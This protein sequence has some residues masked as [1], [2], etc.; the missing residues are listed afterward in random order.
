MRHPRASARGREG[1]AGALH[2][3]Q[4][5]PSAEPGRDLRQ[6]LVG[7]HEAGVARAHHAAAPAQGRQRARGGRVRAHQLG[8]RLRT[9]HRAPRED[10]RH[11]PEEV[12]AVHRA[13]PDAGA[14]GPV[15]AAV[16]HAQLCGAR[17]LLLGQHGRG[18]DLHHRRQLL[19][20]RRAG[21]G[22][23]QAVRDD[24]HGRRPSQQPD[25]DRHQQV[26]ARGRALHLDQSGAHRLFGDC[27]RVD[28]HQAGNGRRAVHGAAAR[29][30]RKR[31]G[32]PCLPQTLHQRAAAR[33][34]RRLRAPGPVRLRPR[35]AARPARRRPQPAQQAG[36]GQ[37]QRQREK[38]LPRRHCRGLR[39]GARRPLHAGRRHAR[40]AVVPA[41][42]RA[43]GQLHARVGTGH[44][45]HRRRA[46]PQAGA[47]DGRDGAEAGLRAADS[48]DRRLG[49]EA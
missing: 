20:I 25:E 28:S 15:R 35:P 32:R 38:R 37:G 24:R 5:G 13:G 29:A 1:P 22:A 46:H 44:H 26:Q 9:A 14:H 8:A 3:R 45:R 39:P 19:G 34:A 17:R 23:R 49:Q 43:R 48:V 42:A 41:A 30:D 31:P 6:G 36:V 27:R 33:G 18:N 12:R 21:P 2:R 10:P 40:G 7:D 11:R 4:P 16:R 47:R